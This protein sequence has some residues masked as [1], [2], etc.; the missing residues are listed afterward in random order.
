MGFSTTQ[1]HTNSLNP[2]SNFNPSLKNFKPWF[3]VFTLAFEVFKPG[4]EVHIQVSTSKMHNN[5]INLSFNFQPW[6]QNFTSLKYQ[7]RCTGLSCPLVSLPPGDEDTLVQLAPW[8]IKFP[9]V[10]SPPP[11]VSCPR[12]PPPPPPPLFSK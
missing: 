11:W 5:T 8:G 10:S 1:V 4:F 12:P 6:F 7:T 3:E 2:S 9:G